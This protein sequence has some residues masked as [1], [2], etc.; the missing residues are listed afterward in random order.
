MT[1]RVQVILS[2]EEREY[3]RR[4]AERRGQSLSSWM[5]EAARE[6][7]GDEPPQ[8]FRTPEDFHRFFAECDERAGDGREPE[9]EEHRSALERSLRSGAADP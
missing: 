3:F 7:A 8:R 5:R 9:W 4:L 1:T 2:E 6:R